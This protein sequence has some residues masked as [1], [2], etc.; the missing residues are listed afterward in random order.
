M[1]RVQSRSLHSIAIRGIAR[2]QLGAA[3]VSRRNHSHAVNR[4]ARQLRAGVLAL[5]MA[6]AIGAW[7]SAAEA[8]LWTRIS[9]VPETPQQAQPT[10]VAI[11]T[12][13]L[14]GQ[15]CWNDPS[16]KPVP[17]DITGW[18]TTGNLP[19]QGLQLVATGPGS[20]RIVLPLTSRR[21]NHSYWDGTI[22]FPSPGSWTLQVGFVGADQ[23][24][25]DPCSGYSRVITVL[26]STVARSSMLPWML[27]GVG[28]AS[29]LLIASALALRARRLRRAE[30]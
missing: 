30:P 29:L 25:D 3:A 2:A 15:Q 28:V 12:F 1:E 27:G 5:M 13:Q 23:P 24:L 8:V 16:A 18:L 4:R 7:P 22:T 17:I 26:P 19:F 20:Q 21:A 9:L 10:H 14:D 11:Y 6:V